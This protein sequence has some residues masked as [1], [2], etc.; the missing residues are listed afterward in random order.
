MFDFKVSGREA[1]RTAGGTFDAFKIEEAS[2]EIECRGAADCRVIANTVSVRNMWYSP[3]V[4]LPVKVMHVRGEPWQG[5]E[6]DYELVAFELQEG[7]LASAQKPGTEEAV[8][9]APQE[10]AKVSPTPSL[11]RA[12]LTPGIAELPKYSAGDTWRVLLDDGRTVTRKVRSIE[13]D[14]YLLEWAPDRWQYLDRN[15][16][17]RRETTPAGRELSPYLLSQRLLD[18]P[19]TVNKVWEFKILRTHYDD[20]DF[21]GR[22]EVWRVFNFKVVGRESVQ[23]AAGTFEAFKVEEAS[24]EIECRGAANCQV[25]ANTVSV[26]NMWYAPEVKFPVKVA[27]VSGEPWQGQEQDYE[28]VAFD[29]K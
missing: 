19:L 23:T 14:S 18:F 2:H 17:L 5:Q 6:Q 7:R 13:R 26:R 21:A 28:L 1:V 24:H 27:H 8:R 12:T 9:A 15:L 3:E 11:P 16:V 25:I 10:V 20:G 29:L 22:T 4:K